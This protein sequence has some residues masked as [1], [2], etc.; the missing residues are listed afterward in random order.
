VRNRFHKQ[1][2]NL[3]DAI[4]QKAKEF[5]FLLH[6]QVATVEEVVSWADNT[7]IA[8]DH[9]PSELIELSTADPFNIGQI[10]EHLTRLSEGANALEAFISTLSRSYQHL[11]S[12]PDDLDHLAFS[13]YFLA[14]MF[15]PDVRNQFAFLDRFEDA[16][17]L[18]RDG[19]YGDI[20]TVRR[21]FL[22]ELKRFAKPDPRTNKET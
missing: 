18:A 20:E 22:D 11:L 9:P 19:S 3:T 12:Q 7:I 21:E 8:M 13:L 14:M 5:G 17:S 15:E 4:K 10:D 6:M 16:T 1:G 2:G